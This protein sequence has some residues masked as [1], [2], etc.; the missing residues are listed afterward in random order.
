[1]AEKKVKMIAVTRVGI[2]EGKVIL[3]DQAFE[4]AEGEVERLEKAGAAKRVEAKKGE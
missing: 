2:G 3:P 1:M 4:I